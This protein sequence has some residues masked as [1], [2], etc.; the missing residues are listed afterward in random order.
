MVYGGINQSCC[1]KDGFYI[2]TEVGIVFTWT[3]YNG[4]N[5][6]IYML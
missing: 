1:S 4:I 2:G 3:V 5:G 6:D